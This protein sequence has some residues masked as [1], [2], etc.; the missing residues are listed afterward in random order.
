MSKEGLEKSKN[1]TRVLESLG[2]DSREMLVTEKDRFGGDMDV[3]ERLAQ[4][5]TE[6]QVCR[7]VAAHFGG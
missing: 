4:D 7:K 1:G 3:T 2:C 6:E 5:G